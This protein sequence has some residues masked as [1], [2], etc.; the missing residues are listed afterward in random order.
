MSERPGNPPLQRL[1]I[2]SVGQQ[3]GMLPAA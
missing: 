3:G 1:W 2:G